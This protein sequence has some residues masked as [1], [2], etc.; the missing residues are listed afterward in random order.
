M[1]FPTNSVTPNQHFSP[2]T[3]VEV[4][5]RN[6]PI[7]RISLGQ[8]PGYD[9]GLQ[10]IITNQNNPRYSISLRTLQETT[11]KI[12]LSKLSPAEIQDRKI[13]NV[14]IAS[15]PITGSRELE[16]AKLFD[17]HVCSI[18]F[19][20]K[21]F[22]TLPTTAHMNLQRSLEDPTSY[23]KLKYHLVEDYR[24]INGNYLAAYQ[25]ARNSAATL[26]SPPLEAPDYKLMFQMQSNWIKGHKDVPTI[27]L[28]PTQLPPEAD[29][30]EALAALDDEASLQKVQLENYFLMASQSEP[31]LAMMSSPMAEATDG[32]IDIQIDGSLD[33]AKKIVQMLQG[34]S[35][36]V[37]DEEAYR[38]HLF[39]DQYGI[40]SIKNHLGLRANQYR[41][42]MFCAPHLITS[43][44]DLNLS[45]TRVVT[46]HRPKLEI[47]ME[48][49][50]IYS[51][52]VN[53]IKEIYNDHLRGMLPQLETEEAT[54]A[55]REPALEEKM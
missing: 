43:P 28:I 15:F 17:P 25:A 29:S 49:G 12:D 37:S 47:P 48:L 42:H 52:A 3:Y 41:L 18:S 39:A 44:E 5:H 32:I 1:A 34:E 26:P 51:E 36:E 16:T 9:R 8:C 13:N 20:N 19:D 6:V 50:R 31:I 46:N 10:C 2:N 38:I 24:T 7:P 35:T 4:V 11:I 22:A 55:A 23:S 54:P 33:T 21:A 14:L 27:S 40:D 53:R 30:P 45:M